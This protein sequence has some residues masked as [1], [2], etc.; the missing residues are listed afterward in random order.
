MIVYLTRCSHLVVQTAY[1]IELHAGGTNQNGGSELEIVSSEDGCGLLEVDGR[2][3]TRRFVGGSTVVSGP[4]GAAV[5]AS[6][7]MVAVASNGAVSGLPSSSTPVKRATD[8]SA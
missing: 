3:E 4:E 1:G 5:P 8:C 7:V 6:R 2:P